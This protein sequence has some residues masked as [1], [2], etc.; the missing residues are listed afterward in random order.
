M[1]TR[2]RIFQLFNVYDY[3][4]DLTN[5]DGS[6]VKFITAPNGYGKTTILDFVNAV[7]R[8]SYD[9]MFLVPFQCFELFYEEQGT[10]TIYK[11]AVTRIDEKSDADDTDVVQTISET[12][13]KGYANVEFIVREIKQEVPVAHIMGIR[14]ADY[15][16]YEEEYMV[17]ENIFLTDRRDLEMMLLETESVKHTLRVW[18]PMYDEAFANCIPICRHFGYLRIFNWQNTEGVNVLVA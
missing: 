4:I 2:I 17:P 10:D 1:L 15:S 12:G 9:K 11:Y 13:R 3:D 5:A 16:R 18:L 8:Q 7:M 6:A 14:D